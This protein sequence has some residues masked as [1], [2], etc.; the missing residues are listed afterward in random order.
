MTTIAVSTTNEDTTARHW[1]DFVA[2]YDTLFSADASY[3]SL[4]AAAVSLVPSNARRVLDLGVGTGVLSG[5]CRKAFPD[6]QVTGLD[7]ADNM[8]EKARA[9][10]ADDPK[11]SLAEGS[12][13]DLSQFTED[14]FDAVISNFALH[15]LTQAEKRVCARE[16]WRSLRPGGRFV[17][18]D[19]FCRVM[20]ETGSRERVLDIFELL[21]SKARY[22]L[23][24]AS[25]ERMLLQMDLLPRF[26]RD[27]GEILATTEYWTQA[28]SDAGF[29]APHV[30]TIEPMEIY[31]R[32][33]WA[34][35]PASNGT[36]PAARER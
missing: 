22:Y 36:G 24:N 20:G 32:V 6:V 3:R 25:F 33:V 5:L 2:G 23:H 8:L 34:A 7:P 15:H 27:D 12:A 13:A 28:L 9:R 17:I 14:G 10:F 1:N 26:L 21:T 4:L 30:I 11:V 35:K 29:T 19:Q 16:V 18:A 31:N